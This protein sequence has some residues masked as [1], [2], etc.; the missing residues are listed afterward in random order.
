[1]I[2]SFNNKV[3]SI[4]I[5]ISLIIF[6]LYLLTLLLDKVEGLTAS[7]RAILL[8]SRIS[9]KRNPDSEDTPDYRINEIGCENYECK[10]DD[11][12]I[13]VHKELTAEEIAS[14][15][16][17]NYRLCNNFP[18]YSSLYDEDATSYPKCSND[19][20]CENIRCDNVND[21]RQ[22]GNKLCG[23]E[24]SRLLPLRNCYSKNICDTSEA[25]NA[26]CAPLIDSDD[27]IS[28]LFREIYNHSNPDNLDI[29][30]DE[31]RITPLDYRNYIYSTLLK[32]TS[33]YSF[34]DG[35]LSISGASSDTNCGYNRGLCLQWRGQGAVPPWWASDDDQHHTI[36]KEQIL[37]DDRFKNIGGNL[38]RN[39]IW[40]NLISNYSDTITDDTMDDNDIKNL[41]INLDKVKQ[42]QTDS[43]LDKMFKTTHANRGNVNVNL[44]QFRELI[45]KQ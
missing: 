2:I 4:F 39:I 11:N 17:E 14:D 24:S 36:T 20:C 3:I 33:N 21:E 12:G 31:M 6:L 40:N 38:E 25:D 26:C 5:K 9:G 32:T 7:E 8:S 42:D 34:E 29:S 44:Y 28:T 23:N 18:E 19:I 27:G 35:P 41:I 15:D 13:Y 45:K 22:E 43:Y 30:V 16:N 10:V 37:S 1:M